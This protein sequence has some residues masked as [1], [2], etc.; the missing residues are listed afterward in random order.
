MLDRAYVEE[1][2]RLIVT[3]LRWTATLAFVPIGI[4][5]VVNVAVFTD[6][7]PE[8]LA[9]FGVQT[10]LC[11][12][13]LAAT[14]GRSGE[15]RALPAAMGLVIGMG[16]SLFWSLSLSPG[17]L[18]VLVGPI[19]TVMAASALLFPWGFWPQLVVSGYVASGYLLLPPWP[20]LD[21]A[22]TANVLI[23]L[24]LG[25]ATSVIGALVLDRSRRATF[26]ERERVASLAHQRELLVDAGRELNS[27]LEISELV[28]RVTRHGHRLVGS[29]AASLTLHDERRNVFR[30]AA[31]ST[32]RLGRGHEVIGIEFPAARFDIL[33]GELARAGVLEIPGLP[34][35]DGLATFIHETFGYARTMYVAIQRDGRLLGFLNFNQRAAEP[36]FGE[37][38]VRLAAGIAHQAAIALANARLVDDLQTANR[39]KSDFVSTMS[40]ELRT[41]LH[42]IMGYTDMLEEVDGLERT[43]ALAKMRHAGREL[44]ELIEA[45]LNLNRMEAG[46]DT[47]TFEPVA[48]RE[49]W[50]ELAS[51]FAA[52]PHRSELDLRWEPVNGV[53]LVTDRR[54]LKTILK[55]LVG[56]A[57]KFTPAGQVVVACRPNDT[58]CEFTV[59]D[60]GVG[61]AAEHLP[62]IFDMFRQADSSDSRSYGGAGLGLYIVRRLLD[63]LGGAVGV[64]SEVGRGT[65]FLVRLPLAPDVPLAA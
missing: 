31:T 43:A 27:T 29:D 30:I 59:R 33:A 40:H 54:K 42:V 8:R 4:S 28:E 49:L 35:F 25:V 61:I 63:Q 65:R 11:A 2:R 12:A 24:S 5:A 15:R 60:T 48:V 38:R 36:A 64:E 55:N 19:G 52:L 47:P 20:T 17:D 62:I 44:L 1:R 51:E 45:T 7:L 18:D 57:L 14:A 53:E 13:A 56:N 41:P 32:D 34:G 9:T 50:D 21:A 10:G 46:K 58:A 22:R 26:V 6:R 39:V 23:S 16:T 3:R 37:H